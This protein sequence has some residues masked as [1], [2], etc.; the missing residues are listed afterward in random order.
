MVYSRSREP[1]D[2]IN[3]AKANGY[4]RGAHIEED[5]IFEK[6]KHVTKTRRDQD[7]TLR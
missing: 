3:K 2:L 4:Q 5:Q 7:S 6:A 1:K